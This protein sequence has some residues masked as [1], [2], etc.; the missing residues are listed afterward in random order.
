MALPSVSG[1]RTISKYSQQ[2]VDAVVEATT[3]IFIGRENQPLLVQQMPEF[4]ERFAVQ[5]QQAKDMMR[6]LGDADGREYV[7]ITKFIANS[8]Q[9]SRKYPL[10]PLVL[11]LDD[12]TSAESDANGLGVSAGADEADDDENNKM[13]E[14]GRMAR[15]SACNSQWYR[16]REKKR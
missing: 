5:K 13:N 7:P 1:R 11:T 8:T 3:I 12:D 10:E 9:M 15:W 2:L 16:T 14:S 4:F 6:M